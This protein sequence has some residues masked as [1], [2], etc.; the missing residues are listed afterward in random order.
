MKGKEPVRA[1]VESGTLNAGCQIEEPLRALNA[2]CPY[3]TMFPLEFPLRVLADG[4]S[5]G[6]W[7]VDPFCGRGTTNFAAR[8]LGL[9]SFGVDSSPVAVALTK[10]KL[11][12]SRACD[13]VRV[14]KSILTSIPPSVSVPE[15]DFWNLAFE[16]S[17]LRSICWLRKELLR[18][19]SSDARLLLRAIL[20]GALHGP[21]TKSVASHLSNQSP[22]TFAPKPNYAVRFWRERGMKPP[23]VD[24]VEVV[25]VRARRYLTRRPKTTLAQVV[26]GDSRDAK[27]FG[28]HRFR[29]VIT[30]PPYYGM[31]TY[32]PDQWLR[33]W[34]LGG[35]AE[36]AYKPPAQELDH[37]SSA[38]FADDL[39]KVWKNIANHVVSDAK[40]IIRF[41]GIADREVDH[42]D[43]L[44]ASLVDSGWKLTSTVSA[45]DANRGRR[46]ARQFAHGGPE[47]KEEYDFYAVRD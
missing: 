22:R 14:A 21:R 6:G 35:P 47:P 45:G 44:R 46:Q 12:D 33:N 24:I 8:L 10:A 3:Y 11:A 27:I 13:V 25:S 16:S 4:A 40:L 36:V 17:V 38:A 39:R 42:L 9:P 31:R 23:T 34:F 1:Q 18:D 5:R 43:L 2:V 37:G 26:L 30:S 32:I 41:G 20:L 19:C 29:W 28:S 7:V 15:G